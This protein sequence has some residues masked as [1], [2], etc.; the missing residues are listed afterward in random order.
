MHTESVKTFNK[1]NEIKTDFAAMLQNE[2]TWVFIFDCTSLSPQGVTLISHKML[3]HFLFS[4]TIRSIKLLHLSCSPDIVRVTKLF[5]CSVC[6]N[7]LSC[8]SVFWCLLF[9]LC[10]PHAYQIITPVNTV[11]L[12]IFPNFFFFF[13]FLYLTK[14]RMSAQYYRPHAWHTTILI[15]HLPHKL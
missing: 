1:T 3:Q 11:G 13:Y 5:S 7:H 4:L 2:N 6:N 12:E 8:W 10:T 14:V 9:K 15:H